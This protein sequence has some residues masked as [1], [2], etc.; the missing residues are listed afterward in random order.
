MITQ[1]TTE[2]GATYVF[3][4]MSMMYIKVTEDESSNWLPFANVTKLE[5][6][7]PM[8]I[9]WIDGENLF[10]EVSSPVVNVQVI[11]VTDDERAQGIED[12]ILPEDVG[13]G[14]ASSVQNWSEM[15]KLLE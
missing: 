8:E 14:D 3:D 12:E 7:H 1:V 10:T 13:E 6:G 2:N 9:L 5:E 11:P 4:D 15:G